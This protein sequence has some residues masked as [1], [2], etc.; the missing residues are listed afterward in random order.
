MYQ[1]LGRTRST[2]MSHGFHTAN[3]EVSMTGKQAAVS[4]DTLPIR[5]QSK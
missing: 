1:F 3:K 4:K 5:L 2:Q